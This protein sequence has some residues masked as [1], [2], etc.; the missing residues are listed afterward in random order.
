MWGPA[1]THQL[2][3]NVLVSEA[4]GSANVGAPPMKL[5]VLL[6]FTCTVLSSAVGAEEKPRV[7]S[8]DGKFAVRLEPDGRS[9]QF[10]QKSKGGGLGH[11][12]R[13]ENQFLARGIRAPELP[14]IASAVEYVGSCGAARVLGARRCAFSRGRAVD[15]TGKACSECSEI[16]RRH[17]SFDLL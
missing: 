4:R 9:V 7:V 10:P 2:I 5:I 11:D 12:C 17:R 1:R 8:P 15:A 6:V 14:P 3:E 16:F 13:E